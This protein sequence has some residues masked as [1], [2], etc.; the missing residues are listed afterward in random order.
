MVRR[1]V[2]CVLLLGLVLVP[3][4]AMAIDHCAAMGQMCEAPCGATVGA[5]VLP[6]SSPATVVSALELQ[7]AAALPVM[8]AR[9]SE[10]PPKSHAL[11]A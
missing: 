11:A 1:V 2:A 10:P 6:G 9:P 5:I 3:P 4:V 7:P 8:F